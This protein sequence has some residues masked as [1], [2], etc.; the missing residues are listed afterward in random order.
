MERHP[1]KA[2]WRCT[3]MV[4]GVQ[5]A[6]MAGIRLQQAWRADSWATLVSRLQLYIHHVLLSYFFSSLPSSLPPF[7]YPSPL[8]LFLLPLS[9]SLPSPIPP[10]SSLVFP[11]P[12][13]SP[14]H[15]YRCNVSHNRCC[16]WDGQSSRG[17]HL[18]V[19][20]GNGGTVCQLH[21]HL[22]CFPLQPVSDISCW[23]TLSW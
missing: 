7:L 11:P 3:G 17:C 15:C 14:L 21:H 5:C 2:D 23:S 18:R 8:L 16:L 9:P 13:P 4:T 22:C 12:Y 6:A 1:G 19:L 10:S 20:S